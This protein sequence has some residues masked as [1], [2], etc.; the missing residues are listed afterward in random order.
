MPGRVCVSGGSPK[1]DRNAPPGVFQPLKTNIW[2]L[3]FCIFS[4]HEWVVEGKVSIPFLFE[5]I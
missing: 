4:L 3:Y 2:N 1:A 5:N